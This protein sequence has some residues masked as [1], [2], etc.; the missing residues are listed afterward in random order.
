M[1]C[2]YT[3]L[4]KRRQRV[5][6]T[7]TNGH[8]PLELFTRRRWENGTMHEPWSVPY[9]SS[10]REQHPRHL[11]TIQSSWPNQ[12]QFEGL[13][14][15]KEVSISLCPTIAVDSCQ[16]MCCP[17]FGL[18]CEIRSAVLFC[19]DCTSNVKKWRIESCFDSNVR[20]LFRE[21]S[22]HAACGR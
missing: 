15:A 13:A 18:E 12:L 22:P 1:S 20:K 9:F 3:L 17:V 7:L 8:L 16:V 14:H 4:F 21:T 10:A 11:V 2:Y 6:A 5:K 19:Y